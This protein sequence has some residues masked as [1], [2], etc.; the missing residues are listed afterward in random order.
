MLETLVASL[1]D[2]VPE[3]SKLL[4]VLEKFSQF[5]DQL[6]DTS[7]PT[8]GQW[9]GN[10]S[11][12]ACRRLER[13]L[14]D[15][16]RFNE[17][18]EPPVTLVVRLAR[19]LTKAINEIAKTP[20]VMLQRR[21]TMEPLHRLREMDSGCMQW[22]VKQPG[23]SLLEKTGNKR[24]MLVVQ[25]FESVDTLENRVFVDF[26][27]RSLVEAERYLREYEPLFPDHPSILV[28]LSFKRRLKQV[29]AQSEFKDVNVLPSVP[30]PN[31]ALLHE[32]RYH[33]I[34]W[35]YQL[36]IRQHIRRRQLWFHRVA[37]WSEL[38]YVSLMGEMEKLARLFDESKAAGSLR[39]DC[40]IQERTRDGQKI[41]SRSFSP[42]WVLKPEKCI[43]V[44]RRTELQHLDEAI[45]S[46]D[47]H[48]VCAAVIVGSE[49]RTQYITLRPEFSSSDPML[50]LHLEFE[51]SGV[52]QE[53]ITIRNL[54]G[55][56]MSDTGAVEACLH[57]L[58]TN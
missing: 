7:I 53:R 27:K 8:L 57:R 28:T 1:E 55:D 30:Q 21:R 31:Y 15:W 19:R 32:S 4:D 10:I 2:D 35:G 37:A 52:V 5:L 58:W 9:E 40:W 49:R 16:R 42:M 6:Y 47:P 11:N 38:L 41:S 25:R 13:V 46:S 51:E 20:R 3:N 17:T 48:L 45:N 34:W 24:S 29:L 14:S 33:Q 39:T 54:S 36:L 26:L 43:L 44:A 23:R 50:D 18:D 56:L 22:L 12:I